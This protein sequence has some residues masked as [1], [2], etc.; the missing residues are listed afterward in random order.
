MVRLGGTAVAAR[1]LL[2]LLR[3]WKG[4]AVETGEAPQGV[5]GKDSLWNAV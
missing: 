5:T 2:L 4:R 3:I 1:L